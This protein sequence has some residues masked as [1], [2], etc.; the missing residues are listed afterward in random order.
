MSSSVSEGEFVT[1]G[2]K[3]SL[4][5]DA[6]TGVAE[7]EGSLVATRIGIVALDG[8]CVTVSPA[9]DGPRL[10]EVGDVVIGQVAR[11]QTKTAEIKILHVE[12]KPIRDLPAEQLFGDVFVA[13]VVD[14]FLPA[15][16]DA[17]RLNDV[18]RAEVI[19]TKPVMRLSTKTKARYGVLHAACPACGEI[20][21]PSDAVD[22]F[23]VACTRCDYTAYR[24]LA[25]DYGHGFFEEGSGNSA[26]NRGGERWSS[27]AEA[28]LSHDG[29]RPYLSPLADYRRGSVH[30]IPKQFLGRGS[31]GGGRGG[32]DSRPRRE[33]HKTKCTLCSDD[34]EVPFKPTP[35]KPI[36]CRPCMA[37]IED[38]EATPDELAAERKILLAAKA[39]GQE[40]AG[41]KM[42]IGGLPYET[43]QEELTALFAEHGELKEV[44]I[45]T[46]R[47]TGQGKGFAFITYASHATG[48]KA[49]PNL[50][51][52]KLGGRKLTV[53]EAKSG[54]G[55]G[56]D[57]RGGRGG[58]NRGR[59]NRRE[60]R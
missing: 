2:E 56:G 33:M 14:R 34:C 32:R 8:E 40:T 25:D 22:D 37:K 57:R 6:G 46:D 53:Q 42:F 12:G 21:V 48:K 28:R 23:N 18:I 52:L 20:L 54:G 45:A 10:P 50:K 30:E 9:T 39:A 55:R 35:G 26:L 59:D 4:S 41:F 38:G 47:E 44:H 43:D 36:R 16:G 17:M 58:G 1:P 19:Q 27:D 3:I 51:N 7:V 24:G 5:G 31:G 49:L 60:R 29:S 13:E 15:P 11:L